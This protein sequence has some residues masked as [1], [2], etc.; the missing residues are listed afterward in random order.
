MRLTTLLDELDHGG[1]GPWPPSSAPSV[2][3]PFGGEFDQVI[4]SL[5]PCRQNDAELLVRRA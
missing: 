1:N 2:T 3:D 4:S 5:I